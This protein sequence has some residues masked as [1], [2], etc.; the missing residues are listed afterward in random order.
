M[1]KSEIIAGLAELPDDAEVLLAIITPP[2]EDDDKGF[3]IGG[4]EDA[5]E[6]DDDTVINE[7]GTVTNFEPIDDVQILENEDPETGAKEKFAVLT[8]DMTDDEGDDED[9]TDSSDAGSSVP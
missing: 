9:E 6:D 8:I 2:D 5:A 7:D 4:S 3:E 1:K